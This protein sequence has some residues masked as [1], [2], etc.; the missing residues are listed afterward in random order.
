MASSTNLCDI[1]LLDG[2]YELFRS[3]F[4][5]PE[6]RHQGREVGA[7][8]GLLRSLGSMLLT[9][10]VTHAAVAFDHVIES[11]R[12]ELFDGYKR[13]DGID[14]ALFGQFPLAEEASLALG[15][16]TWPMVE[17]EADDALAAA[18]CALD[19]NP[20]VGQVLICT[21]DKDLAQCVVSSRVV[22]WDR[23]KDEIIDEDGVLEKY[24]VKPS[25]IPHFLALVGDA[26]D[27]IPGIPAWGEKSAAAVLRRYETVGN[28]P[29]S[30]SEWDIKV[31]GAKRL[32]T[33]LEAERTAAALYVTLATLRRDVPLD[34]GL[35]AVRWQG[36]NP[37]LLRSLC[38]S[39][40]DERFA[41]RFLKQCEGAGVPF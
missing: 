27:G 40:G 14:P 9:R 12:N 29:R 22:R 33:N 36:P 25:S 8:R 18:A 13:G 32:S 34:F 2:T 26:A 39:I 30:E 1:Y 10:K 11:F 3:F 7:T 17:F 28:I 37:D 6:T 4:G 21:P 31:R 19:Q 16:T 24:G 5:A 20:A 23:K 41:D 35:E 15:L 38:D